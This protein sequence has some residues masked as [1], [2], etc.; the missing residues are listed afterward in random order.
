MGILVFLKN[1]VLI[2]IDGSKL[3]AIE[4]SWGVSENFLTLRGIC[5]N[6]QTLGESVKFPQ[7]LSFYTY[8]LETREFFVLRKLV[9]ETFSVSKNFQVNLL[10]TT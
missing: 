1:C 8:K 2:C 7:F 5:K 9:K 6:D 3:R 10:V 4:S